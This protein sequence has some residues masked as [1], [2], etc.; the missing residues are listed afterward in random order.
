MAWYYVASGPKDWDT[1]SATNP[2]IMASYNAGI[3]P[4]AITY[5]YANVD[6]SSIPDGDVI[7]AARLYWDEHSY[8]V[9]GRRL[10][11]KIYLVDMWN[12]AGGGSWALLGGYTFTT[13]A[14]KSHILT[15]TE[16]GYI[17]K[18]GE[19]KIRIRVEYPGAGNARFYYTKA[20]ET[21]QFNAP[22]LN[23]T[24][25]PASSTPQR[26]MVGVGI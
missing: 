4:S 16:L 8:T 12:P 11:A 1:L 19:T 7:S 21:S 23:V 2:T 14:T 6:T 13:A 25:A 5:A 10:P 3:T 9:T 24:H 20:Y 22:R 17:D 26:T 18:T 15:P